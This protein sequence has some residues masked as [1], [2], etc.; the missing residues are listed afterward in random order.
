[1]HGEVVLNNPFCNGAY[2][3]LESQVVE[4]VRSHI[5]KSAD[6]PEAGGILIGYR[7]GLHV[8]VIEATSPTKH[9]SRSRFSFSRNCAS[10]S[11]RARA[12][13]SQSG[14][15]LDYVGE[16]HTHPEAI[17][18]PSHLDKTEWRKIT[19]LNHSSFLFVIAGNAECW[20]LGM[21]K[22]YQIRQIEQ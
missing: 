14:G 10:H 5:Q 22:G 15:I 7:R 19:L 4:T 20:W 3:L 8:H 16:W 21:G 11:N 9:D 2:I 12:L 1:M 13:W 6:A 17:P 18:S